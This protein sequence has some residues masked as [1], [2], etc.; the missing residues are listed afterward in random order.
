MNKTEF[1][2]QYLNASNHSIAQMA[3]DP[4]YTNSI[5]KIADQC[6]KRLQSGNKLLFIGNGGSAADCQH[7]AGEY[8][9][10]FL[11]D[12]DGLPAVALTT[13][14]SILTAIGNDYGY[15]K[16]FS[17]QVQAL[18]VAG[19]LL[20]AYSTS[21]NSENILNAVE[22]A[23]KMNICVVGMT[24]MKAGKLDDLCDFLIRTPSSQT[25]QIQEGHLV[26]GHAICALVEEQFFNNS[27]DK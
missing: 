14:S 26:V 25:P 23:R 13:D 6:V 19:D 9:S 16:L 11:F 20:F 12:R 4:L 10:R 15:Q 18:G 8:V 27:E 21:G 24:G 1:I 22:I 2:N 17:R 7:M 3:T 5:I